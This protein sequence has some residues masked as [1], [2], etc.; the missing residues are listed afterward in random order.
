MSQTRNSFITFPDKTTVQASEISH[1]SPDK[2]SPTP[3]WKMFL[4]S[5]TVLV[6]TKSEHDSLLRVLKEDLYSTDLVEIESD[7]N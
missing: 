3:L 5:G 7:E 4:K 6:L 1:I 2:T